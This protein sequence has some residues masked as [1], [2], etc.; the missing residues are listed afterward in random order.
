M[1]IRALI[2]KIYGISIKQEQIVCFEYSRCG[3]TKEQEQ[4]IFKIFNDTTC[5]ELSLVPGALE[6]LELLKTRYQIALVTSREDVT[7]R[8][9]EDWISLNRVPHD[10]LIYKK[11]KHDNEYNFNFFIEDNGDF[12][13]SLAKVGVRVLL[14]DYPWNREIQGHHNIKRILGWQEVLEELL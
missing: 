11:M 3:I 1:A 14:F 9:T 4:N 13:I 10:L 6:A 5:G 8:K 12:A 7:R 2:H